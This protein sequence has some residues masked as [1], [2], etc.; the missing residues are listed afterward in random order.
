MDK[1]KL[2]EFC[3][4]IGINCVGIAGI[5]PYYD[6]ENIIKDRTKKIL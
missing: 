4:S 3:K 5:G 6:L 2:K 1:N